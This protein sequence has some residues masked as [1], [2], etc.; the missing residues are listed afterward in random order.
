LN[1]SNINFFLT[2]KNCNSRVFK[3]LLAMLKRMANVTN[4]LARDAKCDTYDTAKLMR[5]DKL[6]DLWE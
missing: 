2:T 6:S 3:R 4:Y 1:R 5:H